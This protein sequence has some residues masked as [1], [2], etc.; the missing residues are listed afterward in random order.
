MDINWIRL[1]KDYVELREKELQKLPFQFN[2]FDELRADENANTRILLRLLSYNVKGNYIFLKSFIEM[3]CKHRTASGILRDKI[4]NPNIKYNKE[5]IDGLIEEPSRAYAIIIE[6]KIHGAPDQHKQ[7][8]RYYETVKNHGVPENSI[9]IIYLTLDGSKI[10]SANSLSPIL[11]DKINDRFIE[12]SYKYDI[13]PWLKNDILPNITRKD[14]LLGSGIEQYINY[15]EKILNMNIY[16]KPSQEIL[17]EYINKELNLNDKSLKD[18]WNALTSC[19]DQINKLQAQLSIMKDTDSNMLKG[20]WDA[21]TKENTSN[22]V[23]ESIRN[24]YYQIFINNIPDSIHFEWCPLNEESLF[25]RTSH[26]MA[27]HVENDKDNHN[28]QRLSRNDILRKNAEGLKYECL[29]SENKNNVIALW[30][31]YYC[32]KPFSEMEEHE[33]RLFL[34]EA[35]KE[36]GQL[37]NIIEETYHKLDKEVE[38]IND[39]RSEI[40]K[41]TNHNWKVWPDNNE[42]AWDLVTSFNDD[43]NQIGIEGSFAINQDKNVV[44]RSY[45]TVWQKRFWTIYE[46]ELLGRYNGCTLDTDAG[47]SG[48][49]VYLHL[50][51]IPMGEDLNNWNMK[52]HEIIDQLT[53]TYTFMQ[54][55][56]SRIGN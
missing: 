14:Y 46:A 49:R 23:N 56:T 44:F 6:N 53:D 28:M 54:G 50:P 33:R 19:I 32:S 24:G 30:K 3:M 11:K 55:L 22:Q 39:L 17:T 43:A 2:I 7:I 36:V 40:S 12:F 35:Y 9:Y 48:N 52:K 1:S 34:S 31:N 4:S 27:L 8:E 29:F 45:I 18:R 21:I 26:A 51:E 42:T 47:G 10:V 13:L 16:E 37:Q 15:I 5:Y 41:V 20:S 38:C 25:N